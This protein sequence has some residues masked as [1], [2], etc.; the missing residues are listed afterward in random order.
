MI[1]KQSDKKSGIVFDHTRNLFYFSTELGTYQ[2]NRFTLPKHYADVQAKTLIAQQKLTS[3]YVDSHCVQCRMIRCGRDNM[4]LLQSP[5]VQCSERLVCTSLQSDLNNSVRV[6]SSVVHTEELDVQRT[7]TT[8]DLCTQTLT[9]GKT[10]EAHQWF[11]NTIGPNGTH[12]TL[13]D[14]LDAS[15]DLRNATETS[16][17]TRTTQ[18]AIMEASDTAHNCNAIINRPKCVIDGRHSLLTGVLEITEECEELL[19]VDARVSQFTLTSSSEYKREQSRPIRITLRNVH[20]HVKDWCFEMKDAVVCFEFCH[21]T[22]Q[23][24]ILGCV[25]NVVFLHS[26]LE[27]DALDRLEIRQQK[28]TS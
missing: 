13:Q 8:K 11:Y 23:N 28:T 24:K 3:P 15:D 20:G 12:R 4:L 1:A 25:N 2:Q 19:I 22:F 27:G 6:S 9:I 21:I 18:H 10:F 14:Y 17:T 16:Q 7:A 26:V 5:L